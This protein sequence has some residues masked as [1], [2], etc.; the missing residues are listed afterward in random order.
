MPLDLMPAS[1]ALELVRICARL[2]LA[3]SLAAANPATRPQQSV[4]DTVM[5]PTKLG[6][7][8]AE[9]HGHV[10]SQFFMHHHLVQEPGGLADRL[11]GHSLLVARPSRP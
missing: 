3:L 11:T 8:A 9:R 2:P 7:E 10:P 1:E 5:A 4:A 6:L